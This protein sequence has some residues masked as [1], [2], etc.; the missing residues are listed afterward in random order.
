LAIRMHVL[1]FFALMHF[2]IKLLKCE[3]NY[4]LS[5]DAV[6]HQNVTPYLSRNVRIML[7]YRCIVFLLALGIFFANTLCEIASCLIKIQKG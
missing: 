5:A 7:F 2:G 6:L 4:M 1:F 3:N